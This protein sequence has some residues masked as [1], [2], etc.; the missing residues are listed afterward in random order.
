M[1]FDFLACYNLYQ[2][3]VQEVMEVIKL[4]SDKITYSSQD[5]SQ[6][7]SNTSRISD[8]GRG[9]PFRDGL[10]SSAFCKALLTYEK[11]PL[12]GQSQ[13]LMQTMDKYSDRRTKTK[14]NCTSTYL[15]KYKMRN[16]KLFSCNC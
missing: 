12:S 9:F 3:I 7:V 4:K 14:Q 1:P 5:L 6:T 15:N 16:G 10:L 2:I 8:S 11:Q 13:T